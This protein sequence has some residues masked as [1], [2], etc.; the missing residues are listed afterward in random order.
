MAFMVAVTSFLYWL[1]R[2]SLL[3]YLQGSLRGPRETVDL[4]SHDEMEHDE[5]E[6]ADE[7]A[8][9]EDRPAVWMPLRPQPP[10]P[11]HSLPQSPC[12]RPGPR[13]WPPRG[14]RNLSA[15]GG[16][17]RRTM[18]RIC[19][20]SPATRERVSPDPGVSPLEHDRGWRYGAVATCGSAPAASTPRP[21]M[22]RTLPKRAGARLVSRRARY[23]AR[24]WATH[25][26][27][28]TR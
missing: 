18:H 22:P 5:R 15:R 17:L 20:G 7:G 2:A 27:R 24:K 4:P 13:A 1:Q 3:S 6:N 21:M 9:R 11:P 25:K 23:K 14:L 16:A 12:Q 28:T 8:W 26:M 10:Q 19:P